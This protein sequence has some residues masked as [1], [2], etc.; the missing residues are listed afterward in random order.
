VTSAFGIDHHYPDD[1][2]E[3]SKALPGGAVL[4][5]VGSA[6]RGKARQA[7]LAVGAR[8]ESRD[9]GTRDKIYQQ[10]RRETAGG[11]R[12]TGAADKYRGRHRS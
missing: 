1:S 8:R 7:Q 11:R 3:L 4:R 10:L 5:R 9:Y 6:A 12:R 2:D